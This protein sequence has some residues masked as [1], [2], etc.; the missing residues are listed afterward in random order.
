MQAL[1]RYTREDLRPT[2]D[3]GWLRLYGLLPQ[4]WE[5]TVDDVLRLKDIPA[6]DRV[7]TVLHKRLVDDRVLRL[8]ACACVQKMIVPQYLESES[9]VSGQSDLS[10]CESILEICERYARGDASKNE[11]EAARIFANHGSNVYLGHC[12]WLALEGATQPDAV[13]AALIAVSMTAISA[14]LHAA[15]HDDNE[16]AEDSADEQS[17]QFAAEKLLALLLE[18]QFD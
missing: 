7:W 1:Q 10:L 8:F 4:E 17:W 16:S 2:D 5:G 6:H 11:L 3:T 15:R 9:V 14:R 13:T 12:F 18:H